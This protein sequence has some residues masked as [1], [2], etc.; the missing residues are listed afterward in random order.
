VI[1]D[2]PRDHFVESVE[3]ADLDHRDAGGRCWWTSPR[4][5][6]LLTF[7]ASPIGRVARL[8]W[9]GTPRSNR[10][11]ARALVVLG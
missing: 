8:Q 4:Y 9:T 6:P 3:V 10:G 5:Y 2:V 7:S 1:D 11:P